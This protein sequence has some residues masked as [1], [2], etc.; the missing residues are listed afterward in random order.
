MYCYATD[1][2]LL[3]NKPMGPF[4]NTFG[5]GTSPIIVDDRVI[6]CQD[7]DTDSFLIANQVYSDHPL[8]VVEADRF[9]EEQTRIGALL[10]AGLLAD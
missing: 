8:T 6:L 5:S 9:V 2:R 10:G 1:G 3:W 4:N 7:H